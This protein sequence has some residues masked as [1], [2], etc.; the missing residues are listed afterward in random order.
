M[1][2]NLFLL[3]N[4][5]ALTLPFLGAEVQNQ[6]Q[7][8]CHEDDERTVNEKTV[9]FSPI[10]IPDRYFTSILYPARSAI[11]NIYQYLPLPYYL[12]P[13]VV[14]SHAQ[15]SQRQNFQPPTIG[16]PQHLHPSLYVIRPKTTQAS[17]VIPTTNTAATVEPTFV[18]TTEPT[19]QTSVTPQASSEFAITSTPETTTVPITSTVV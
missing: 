12:K 1:M 5:L 15:I 7:P 14:R 6:E 18:P 11:A 3:L 17:T 13:V 2:R 19:E 10:Y 4:I 16:R 9:K 8:T